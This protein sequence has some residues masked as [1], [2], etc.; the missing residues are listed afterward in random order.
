MLSWVKLGRVGSQN[1]GSFV[2]NTIAMLSAAILLHL[3]G[4]LVK[5]RVIALGQRREAR[6][7]NSHGGCAEDCAVCCWCSL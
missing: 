2:T 7:W 5:T 3:D 4:K 1:E 6:E